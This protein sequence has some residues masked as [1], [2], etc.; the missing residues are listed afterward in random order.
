LDAP[1]FV[2]IV[3]PLSWRKEE[4]PVSD[5]QVARK[6]SGLALRPIQ[7]F[8]L[9]DAIDAAPAL[10]F[11][12]DDEMSY[13]AVNRNACE[14]LGYSREELLSMRVTDVAVSVEAPSLF[15]QM[16]RERS[17]QGAVELLTKDGVLLPFI[18]EA[19]ETQIG[20]MQ[21]WVSVG[22]VNSPLHEKVGQLERALLTR[23]VI[24]QAKGVLV[25]RHH[26]DPVTAFEALRA[27]ARSNNLRLHDLAR[28]T[29]EETDT[30]P[31]IV[32]R[33]RGKPGNRVHGRDRT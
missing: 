20:G 29:V 14:V 10:I 24:E 13:V 4:V 22:F 21:Y 15:E 8:L 30:P 23:V 32:A 25:G 12:A 5:R 27:A 17:Q 16:M 2:E 19:A 28:R 1:E 31:E 18:Y 26:V 11:V 3:L 33:L 9:Y 7:Q 6:I